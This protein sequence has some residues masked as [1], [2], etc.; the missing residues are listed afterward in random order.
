MSGSRCFIRARSPPPPSH[1]NGLRFYKLPLTF[2]SLWSCVTAGSRSHSCLPLDFPHQICSEIFPWDIERKRVDREKGLSL[3]WTCNFQ[4]LGVLE[5]WD[6]CVSVW[7]RQRGERWGPLGISW[8]SQ[9]RDRFWA[10][11]KQQFHSRAGLFK[12]LALETQEEWADLELSLKKR[13]LR[14]I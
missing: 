10:K 9:P 6:A 1:V 7:L 12:S 5:R 14:V 13:R 3:I 2:Q 4:S 8:H 11:G